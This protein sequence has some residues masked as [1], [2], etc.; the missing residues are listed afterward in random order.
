MDDVLKKYKSK[1]EL[2]SFTD[3]NGFKAYRDDKGRFVKG[4]SGNRKGG[5]QPRIKRK[6]RFKYGYEQ[7]PWKKDKIAEGIRK[8]MSDQTTK[9][10]LSQL[11]EAADFVKNHPKNKDNKNIFQILFEM[12]FINKIESVANTILKTL[13]KKI[14]DDLWG[15]EKQEIK[16]L[17]IK[18]YVTECDKCGGKKV[19]EE[20][21]EEEIN[22]S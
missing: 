16:K 8:H 7:N 17:T 21:E 2:I 4:F 5:N 22:W 18:K 12:A 1:D 6:K 9:E 15:I 20:T 14:W 13:D 3:K 10:T 11:Q 19:E